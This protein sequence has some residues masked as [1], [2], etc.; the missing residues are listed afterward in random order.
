MLVNQIAI[1]FFYILHILLF[2]AKNVFVI[3]PYPLFYKHGLYEFGLMDHQR[4]LEA[5]QGPC[6]LV[7][8]MSMYEHYSFVDICPFLCLLS[9]IEWFE[10][11]IWNP[12]YKM[13]TSNF[14]GIV[15]I[16]FLISIKLSLKWALDESSLTR[17]TFLCRWPSWILVPE[18]KCTGGKC[19]W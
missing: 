18:V 14:R 2:E 13:K 11:E 15:P 12:P 9:K 5:N 17:F 10:W 7:V 6:E 16:Q 1:T 8:F 4:S 3:T 19:T